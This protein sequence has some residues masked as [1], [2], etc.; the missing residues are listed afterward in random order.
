L[1][2]FADNGHMIKMREAF[3]AP[4]RTAYV[5]RADRRHDKDGS[6]GLTCTFH[7]PT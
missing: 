6:I 1:M 7:Q 5:S 4:Y 2:T 3:A